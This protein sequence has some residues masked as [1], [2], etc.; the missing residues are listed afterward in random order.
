MKLKIKI[1]LHKNA[2]KKPPPIFFFF[3]GL[4]NVSGIGMYKCLL[5]RSLIRCCLP[6]YI[7]EISCNVTFYFNLQASSNY[8]LL[9][10]KMTFSDD[11]VDVVRRY[12]FIFHGFQNY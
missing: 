12:Q 2:K 10:L 5:S 9:V 3:R 4:I 7:R 11:V 8:Y 6:G 1:Q